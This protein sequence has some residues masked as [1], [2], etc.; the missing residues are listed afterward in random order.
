LTDKGKK[1]KADAV[2]K[3][4]DAINRQGWNK[5][6]GKT[7]LEC[8]WYWPDGRAHDANNLHKLLCDALQGSVYRN[9]RVALVRDMDYS[10]D[11]KNPRVEL[12]IYPKRNGA[13][14]GRND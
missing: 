11:K 6:E 7:I 5:T 2:V 12:V 10:I 13:E 1:W 3:A 9:D 14:N 4:T 8:T